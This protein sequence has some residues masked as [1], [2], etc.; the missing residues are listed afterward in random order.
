MTIVSGRKSF[1]DTG[2]PKA[3]ADISVMPAS[4]AEL[5]KAAVFEGFDETGLLAV[6]I[7]CGTA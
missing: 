3:K 4:V 7:R 6:A 2:R 5:G 1:A